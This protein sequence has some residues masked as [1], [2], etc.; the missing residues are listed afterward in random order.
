MYKLRAAIVKDLRVLLRDKIGLA[1][2]F[3]MPVVLVIVVTNIQS[4]TFQLLNKNKLTVLLLNR[5]TGRLSREFLQTLDK[6]G[7]FRIKQLSAKVT[8]VQL[9]EG[10]HQKDALL[11]ITVPASFTGDVLYKAKNTAGK[12]MKSFGLEGDSAKHTAGNLP[13][14]VYYQPSLPESY[15]LSVQGA[16]RSAVQIVESKET[17]RQLYL[18]INDKPLPAKMENELLQ[19]QTQIRERAV[20]GGQDVKTPDATQ[21][22][23][24]A[25]TIFAMFFVII[26]LAGSIIREK[27]SGS[28]VRLKTLPTSYALA[29]FARQLTYLAVT[30]LQALVVFAIGIWLFPVIGLPGLQLPQDVLGFFVITLIIGWAA[31]SYAVCAGVFFNTEE[32]ANSFGAISIV[33]LAAIGGLMVPSFAMPSSFSTAINL[34]PLHWCLEAYNIL[35]LENGRLPDAV[36]YLIPLLIMICVMQAAA[37]AGLKRK[38]LI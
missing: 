21:H 34:S 22:N 5:D 3:L 29:L 15:H 14:D 11:A 31:V 10:L 16:V 9:R 20:A 30:V 7:L 2:M 23:V 28:F 12:A 32:Q 18:A 4:S 13:L 8:D 35:F 24:P 36:N 6:T 19:N 25:W 17:L 37:F 27:R 1:F 33:I 26:S 38:N